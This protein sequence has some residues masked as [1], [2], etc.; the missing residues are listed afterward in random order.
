[1]ITKIAHLAD[2]HIPKSTTRHEEFRTV[3]DRTYKSLKKDKPDRIVLVGDLVH[4]YLDMQG[5]Q[6]ILVKEFLTNLASIAPV[7]ITRGNHDIRKK[8]LQ[9]TDTIQAIVNVL[10]N[11]NIVYYNKTGFNDDENVTWAVWHH[12]EKDNSPWEK[13]GDTKLAQNTTVIDL[14]HNPIGG[15]KNALGYE[16]NSKNIVGIKDFHGHYSFFG[17]IHLKQYFANKTKAYS[18]S[19]IE[20]DF[21]EGDGQFH[22]YLLWDIETGKVKE[23]NINNDFAYNTVAV[24][25]F[26]NFDDLELEVENEK[27]QMKIR[28][29][30]KTYPPTRTKENQRKV[31][32]HLKDKYSN[33][34]VFHKNE[35]IVEDKIEVNEEQIK[36]ITDKTVQEDIFRNYLA[37]IGTDE[38]VI[39]AVIEVDKEITSR[40]SVE[41]LT[42]IEWDV[43]KF[44]AKNFMS[45]KEIEIDWRDMDGLYQITGLNTAGKTT[46]MKLISYLLYSKTL[47]TEKRIKYGDSRYVN[48][49]INDD[50]CE[51]EIVIKANDEIF[52]I[53]KITTIS[54]KK[55]DE[56]KGASTLVKYYKLNSIDDELSDDNDVE[57]LTEEERDSTQKLIEKTV[58]TYENF[59]RVVITTSDTLNEILSNDSSQFI[60]ALLYDSGLDI[61]D[62]KLEVFKDYQK[63]VFKERIVC[64]VEKS[65]EE[66][67]NLNQKINEYNEKISDI[68]KNQIPEVEKSI[69]KGQEFVEDLIKKLH[70]IDD[71]IYNFDIEKANEEINNYK[72]KI[73]ELEENKIRLENSISKLIDNFDQDEFDNIQ[74]QKDE[75]K[76]KFYTL[77]NDITKLDNLIIVEE[78]KIEKIRGDIFKLKEEGSKIKEKANNLK[79]SK[80]CPT[81]GQPIKDEHKKH[82]DEEIKKMIADMQNIA[83]QIEIK[84][85]QE[86]P[87]HEQTIDNYKSEKRENILEIDKLSNKSDEILSKIGELTNQKNDFEKR[88]SLIVERDSIPT[89]IENYEL[90]VDNVNKNID[91]YNKSLSQIEENKKTNQYILAAKHKLMTLETQENELRDDIFEYKT[92]KA[93]F[94]KRILE[95]ENNI[96]NFKEQE[97]KELVLTT[98]KKCTHRTGI[99]TLL[100]INYAIPKINNELYK[101]LEEIPFDVWLDV[102]ENDIRL[103]LAYNSTAEENAA[104]D[105]ISGSG[106]ERTFAS[107]CLKFALNQINAKS[108]PTIFLLDEVMGK[109]TDDSVIEF[110][111][112]LHKIKDRVKK[113]LIVE[114]NHEVNPDYLINV[115]KDENNISHLN[116][117]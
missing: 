82:I 42:S 103:K 93:D 55:D 97:K 6:L 62:K 54:R 76:D 8:N 58:G 22:G 61:F 73:K 46:I 72:N 71:N 21:S 66:I 13:L 3:F 75:I 90:R 48:N 52:G 38:D 83:N 35:F 64:N 68:E 96:A 59:K 102:D 33:T 107:V 112:V 115:V 41:E 91:I 81:C 14:F 44:K 105:A 31:E 4:D 51:G 79:K 7:R 40:M 39:D 47:E 37:E 117:D 27:P 17:D 5:E 113:L 100:L 88:K 86:I 30:W 45:Y 25:Q 43:I 80:I 111:D 49:Y 67:K 101:L 65:E 110:I 57:N 99:P 108:K 109:L 106:K 23:R 29:I 18:S 78:N 12:G 116:I 95:L 87:P 50:F 10:D 56:I 84:E 20:Q 60:D 74:K 11:S 15:S 92:A 2:I 34:I 77:K 9:R 28:V 114:H 70:K 1:M 98:Y 32:K 24:N 36:D 19:L 63:E 89:Q 104:I 94:E 26:T 16:F 85:T 69:K 53:K